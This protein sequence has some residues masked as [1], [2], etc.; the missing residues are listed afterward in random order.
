VAQA[1]KLYDQ[2]CPRDRYGSPEACY[3]SA[4]L[5]ERGGQGVTKDATLAATLYAKGC[6]SFDPDK[7][8]LPEKSC[9]KA[10]AMLTQQKRDKD[11]R[12][13]AGTLC[14]FYRDKKACA[15]MKQLMPPPGPPPGKGPPPAPKGP[16][17]PPK[18]PPPPPPSAKK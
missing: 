8:G 7:T 4:S 5:H 15:Q 13:P 14:G 12:R 10:L 11:A 3:L 17:P 6:S 1:Q 9:R 16:P 2:A 18:G